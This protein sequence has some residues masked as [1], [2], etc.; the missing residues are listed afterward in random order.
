MAAEMGAGE[1]LVF[2]GDA[3]NCDKTVYSTMMSAL[4][5]KGLK[6]F[7]DASG[8]SLADCAKQRPFLIKPNIDELSFLAGR[9]ITDDLDDVLAALASIEALGIAVV[10][11]S[12]GACGSVLWKPDGIWRALPP[13]V[14]V[15]NT[16]GCG[17]TFLAGLLYGYEKGLSMEEMLRIATGASSAAAESALSVGFDTKRAKT[18]TK[19]AE[20]TK[21][22]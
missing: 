12:M 18:L 20:I 14:N 5:H 11:V 10:A 19:Q 15:I 8:P 1:T 22:K 4:R 17:D 3:S 16:V 6:I 2:S 13:P 9:H 21:I 7:L